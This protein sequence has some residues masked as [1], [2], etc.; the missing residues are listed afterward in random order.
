MAAGK[1]RKSDRALR[2]PLQSPG[3]PPVARREHRQQFWKAIARGLA[4]E[5]A[6]VAA[7]VSQAVGT[8]WFRDGGGMPS[9][10]SAPLSERYL[11]FTEREEIALLC[12]QSFGVRAIAQ[13]VGRSPSTISRELRRNAATRCGDLA[14]RATVAQRH[15]DRRSRRPKVAKLAGNEALRQYVQEHIS[16]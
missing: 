14:Y 15:A 7:G 8:R 5:D 4:S 13:K 3:R 16:G 2:P 11:S 9:I 6:A 12:A 10:C 1:H